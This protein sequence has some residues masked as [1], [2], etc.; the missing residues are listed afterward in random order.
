MRRGAI[1]VLLLSGVASALAAQGPALEFEPGGRLVLHSLPTILEDDDVSTH[2]TRGLTTTFLFRVEPE[3]ARARQKPRRLRGATI[4]I[5]YELWD[6]VFH[7]ATGTLDGRVERRTLES[8][9]ELE[10]WWRGLRLTVAGGEPFRAGIDPPRPK[11][12]TVELD[13]VPF[14]QAEQR[15]TRRW[16]SETLDDASRS[17][18][19]TLA[20]TAEKDPDTLERTFH[21]LM[22][23]SIQRRALVSYRWDVPIV[24]GA[25]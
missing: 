25:S 15:D 13:V 1:L 18:T 7:V 16:F 14:S 21:L 2:L 4:E 8:F 11:M 17:G 3:G 6:E 19:E 9:G 22:A 24:Q 20:E 5:R 10:S 23:T 12:A